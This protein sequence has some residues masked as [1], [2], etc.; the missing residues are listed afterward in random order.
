MAGLDKYVVDASVV[1]RWLLPDEK[2][3]GSSEFFGRAKS[4][5]IQILVPE[6]LLYEVLNGIKSALISR[7]LNKQQADGAVKTFMALEIGWQDQKNDSARVM[8]IALKYNLSIYDAAYVA[9]AKKLKVK[10][11]SLDKKLQRL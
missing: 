3:L 8:A 5:K 2:D 11:L 10:L 9:L 7:R 1:L 6:I 4:G